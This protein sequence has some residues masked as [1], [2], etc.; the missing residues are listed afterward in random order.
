MSVGTG[1]ATTSS[2]RGTVFAQATVNSKKKKVAFNGTFYVP[3]LIRNLLSISRLRKADC[4][5]LFDD[6]DNGK[7]ICYVIARETNKV[8]LVAAE[9]HQSGLYEV[10]KRRFISSKNGVTGAEALA[11]K[12]GPRVMWH[13]RLGHI[14]ENTTRMTIP[15]VKGIKLEKVQSIPHCEPCKVAKST[16]SQRKSASEESKAAKKP[17]EL[18]HCDLMGPIRNPSQNNSRYFIPMYDVCTGASLVPLSKS[19]KK[20]PTAFK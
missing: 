20:P 5:I 19:K 17:L 4:R 15:L 1:Q 12:V 16:R 9:C 3:D 18:V 7:G 6:D 14:S 10:L 13:E 11:A 2:G 8:M